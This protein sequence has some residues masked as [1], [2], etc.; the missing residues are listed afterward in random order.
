MPIAFRS[1]STISETDTSVDCPK[2]TG[3]VDG[4]ILVAL[5]VA[6]QDVGIPTITPPAGWTFTVGNSVFNNVRE[7]VYWKRAGSE[8]ASYTWSH[9]GTGSLRTQV[10]IAAYSGALQ[11][12]SP[13]D[14]IDAYSSTW[15]ETDDTTLRAGGVKPTVQ[16]TML[17]FLGQV[18]TSL[19]ATPPAGMTERQDNSGAAYLHYLADQRLTSTAATGDKDA[20]LSGAENYKHAFLLVLKEALPFSPE[21]YLAQG[22]SV[23]SSALNAVNK[24]F[25]IV[26]NSSPLVT[27]TA[28]YD[29]A[30][31][32]LRYS[33]SPR[34]DIVFLKDG[35]AAL[36]NA[37]AAA[38]LV[39]RSH[40]RYY[41]S[42]L[43]VPLRLGLVLDRGRLIHVRSKSGHVDGAYP[44]RSITH[45][46]AGAETTLEVGDY[47]GH[48]ETFEG[49]VVSNAKALLQLARESKI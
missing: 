23:S 31:D 12:G 49:V 8:G 9:D 15:Y 44:I 36:C 41:V 1:V 32:P 45:D 24:V 14:P 17:V 7:E 48:N 22:T 29:T 42:G 13:I 5:V 16:P 10:T 26:E 2:P 30:G 6:R 46:F 18:Y 20:T 40:A 19:S 11:A 21:I 43:T 39:N 47:D 37:V 33:A 35:S 38:H 4:D 25:A 3:A 27:G 28:T 34:E